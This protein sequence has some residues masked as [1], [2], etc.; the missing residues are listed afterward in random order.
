MSTHMACFRLRIVVSAKCVC[1]C[2]TRVV[3]ESC[4]LIFI[5]KC[6]I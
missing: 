2:V 4:G 1:V 6:N 3:P 5:I